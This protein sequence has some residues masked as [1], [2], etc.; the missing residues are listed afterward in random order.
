MTKD[1]DSFF[2]PDQSPSQSSSDNFFI[3]DTK[4]KPSIG[5]AGQAAAGAASYLT[6]PADL[7]QAATRASALDT[8][9]E[10]GESNP[11]SRAAVEESVSKIPTQQGLE[12]YLSK[13]TGYRF[14]PEGFAEKTAR[15]AGQLISPKGL[16]SGGVKEGL[17][18]LGKRGTAAISG[19]AAE[20]GLENLGVNP[21]IASLAG[22]TG[23]SIGDIER[24]F[25][26]EAQEIKNMAKKH[27]LRESQFMVEEAPK[28][29]TAT[30]TKGQAHKIE[31]ELGQTSKTAIQK[32]I[33]DKNSITKLRDEGINLDEYANKILKQTEDIAKT[34]KAPV[35]LSPVISSIDKKISEIKSTAPSL[36]ETDKKFI[37]IL[38]EKR[39]DFANNP[40]ISHEQY[41]NQYRK[42]NSDRKAFYKNPQMTHLQEA[43][44]GAYGFLNEQMIKNAETGAE[45]EFTSSLKAGNKLHAERSNL[46]QI[47]SIFTPF[48]DDPNPKNLEKILKSDKKSAL[49][50]RS[51]GEEGI[52]E[53]KEIGKYVEKAQDKLKENFIQHGESW[54]G[55]I[56]D[57]GLGALGALISPTVAGSIEIGLAASY[58]KGAMLA[59]KKI[60]GDGLNLYKAMASGNEK[61]IRTYSKKFNE[62]ID[63]EYGNPE[64]M[65]SQADSEMAM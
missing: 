53:V 47:E 63:R 57:M 62:S 46:S 38:Q 39:N 20:K 65:I 41:L 43:A 61:A 8:L 60:R 4:S 24:K 6:W 42:N 13:K 19:A 54:V 22:I 18:A 21:F 25:S 1:M 27:S 5:V 34:S 3:P 49:L 56:K 64:D 16:L 2:I 31:S 32:I 40:N 35:S 55:V 7:A 37:D 10:M 59:N 26:K 45:K 17:I 28:L 11:Q 9:K 44:N 23:A 15:G 29:R 50:K 48:F 14:Q 33:K 58:I 12:D 30:I 51:L 52:K 36:S